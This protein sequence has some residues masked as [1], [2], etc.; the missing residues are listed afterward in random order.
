MSRTLL[1]LCIAFSALSGETLAD[2]LKDD[3][4]RAAA[5]AQ[6]SHSLTCSENT[7]PSAFPFRLS[8]TRTWSGQEETQTFG[9]AVDLNRIHN[10]REPSRL[11]SFVQ[12]WQG[13]DP[14]ATQR[15]PIPRVPGS[16]SFR[17]ARLTLTYRF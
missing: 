11:I 5:F 12:A 2:C 15:E 1:V 4:L 14:Y 7:Q 6:G 9:I 16:K 13:R 17:G 10:S 8:V 3:P